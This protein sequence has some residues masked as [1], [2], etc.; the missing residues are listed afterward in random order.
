MLWLPI[1][2]IIGGKLE[3][4]KKQSEKKKFILTHYYHYLHCINN[5]GQLLCLS[6]RISGEFSTG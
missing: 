6:I 2:S 1:F 5:D 4:V 3:S